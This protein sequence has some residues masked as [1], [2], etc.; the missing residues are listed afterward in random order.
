MGR[1]GQEPPGTVAVPV[2]AVI[3]ETQVVE[4]SKATE[5]AVL[6][7]TTTQNRV[8]R[9]AGHHLRA[10]SIGGRYGSHWAVAA[11]FSGRLSKTASGF[12]CIANGVRTGRTIRE[13]T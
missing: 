13:C 7:A 8:V 5:R 11:T 6:A 4:V 3:V 9:E 10:V 2:I 1:H 12:A